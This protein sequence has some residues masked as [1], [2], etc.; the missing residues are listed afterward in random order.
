MVISSINYKPDDPYRLFPLRVNWANSYVESYEFKTDIITTF[1]GKEQRRAFRKYPR[2]ELS[3]SAVLHRSRKLELDYL[4]NS[5]QTKLF[6]LPNFTHYV[7]STSVML[8]EGNTISIT[9][10]Y[11]E[12]I[13]PGDTVVLVNGDVIET[14]YV[15]GVSSSALSFG[16]E[17]LTEWPVGTR[18]HPV[19]LGRLQDEPKLSHITSETA[20]FPAQFKIEPGT[21]LYTPVESGFWLDFREAWMKKPDWKNGLGVDHHWP[22]NTVD[23]EIGR[24]DTYD[25]YKFPSRVTRLEYIS[26]T[27]ADV[28]LA[29]DFFCRHYGQAREFLLPSWEND[30]PYAFISAGSR[31]ILIP[32]LNF[33]TVY[34]E[35]TV[36]RRVVLRMKDGS[37][38]HRKVDFVEGLEE[39]DTSV[40]WVEEPLPSIPLTPE[41]LIGISW[42]PVSRFATDRLEIEWLTDSVAQYTFAVRSLENFDI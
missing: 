18:I 16:D 29:V 36:F 42:V 9:G 15:V 35:S 3:F 5:W 10:P 34:G 14:R 25:P 11:Y 13:S 17:S 23:Y 7:T 1:D 8:A 40:L 31:S 37:D 32:G 19:Q 24:I 22:R 38:I 21:S 39:T 28:K 41:T 26:T 27:R 12:D 4:M 6:A 33:A 30:V 2:R 20:T